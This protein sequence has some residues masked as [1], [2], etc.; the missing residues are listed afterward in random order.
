MWNRGVYLWDVFISYANAEPDGTVAAHMATWL[1]NTGFHFRGHIARCRVFFAP[2]SVGENLYLR[3]GVYSPSRRAPRDKDAAAWSAILRQSLL[4]CYHYVGLVSDSFEQSPF[5]ELEF[6]AFRRI[7]AGNPRRTLT[8]IA[9]GKDNEDRLWRPDMDEYHTPGRDALTR[10]LR[11]LGH[12]GEVCDPRIV[13]QWLPLSDLQPSA[14]AA[15]GMSVCVI[16]T[17]TPHRRRTGRVGS[18]R[19]QLS[20]QVGRDHWAWGYSIT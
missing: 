3:K 12:L 15:S 2:R 16:G 6:Q 17:S 4:R 7:T 1:A 18:G 20:S 19:P 10:L 8:L 14:P 11:D 5:C 13:Y 9:A